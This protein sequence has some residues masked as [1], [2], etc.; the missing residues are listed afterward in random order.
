MLNMLQSIELVLKKFM[1]YLD[2]QDVR[3]RDRFYGDS[4]LNY[5]GG[6]GLMS[7]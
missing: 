3:D 4:V 2:D 6:Q 1:D 7:T 5:L